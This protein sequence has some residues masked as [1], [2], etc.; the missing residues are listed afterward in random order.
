[1]D[2]YLILIYIL[3]WFDIT[4]GIKLR[5]YDREEGVGCDSAAR[6][7]GVREQDVQ[8]TTQEDGNERP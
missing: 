5:R 4:K 8:R 1:M 2:F 3:P 6:F 7:F